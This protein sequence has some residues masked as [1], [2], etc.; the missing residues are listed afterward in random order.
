M[1]EKDK[2]QQASCRTSSVLANI[3]LIHDWH[4]VGLPRRP[5]C[6]FLAHKTM[7]W[8]HEIYLFIH[9]TKFIEHLSWT[10]CCIRYLLN[11]HWKGERRH[12]NKYLHLGQSKFL[13][14]A[15]TL[16]GNWIDRKRTEH[17]TWKKWLEQIR[18]QE[19]WGCLW[20]IGGTWICVKH[21]KVS[22]LGWKE[23]LRLCHEESYTRLRDVAFIPE[24]E[25]S[26]GLSLRMEGIAR[27][28]WCW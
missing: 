14:W 3:L 8:M 6:T 5:Y 1:G 18:Q 16:S 28:V 22:G 19:S 2:L 23:V 10:I 11:D 9:P 20:E 12:I 21:R 25:G 27:V 17:S 4:W 7:E 13:S 15:L 24:T 26:C